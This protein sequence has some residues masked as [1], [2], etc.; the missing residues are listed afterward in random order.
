LARHAIALPLLAMLVL[1]TFAHAGCVLPDLQKGGSGYQISVDPASLSGQLSMQ[2]YV[3]KSDGTQPCAMAAE[4]AQASGY[5]ASVTP[6]EIS[7]NTTYGMYYPTITATA[8]TGAAPGTISIRFMDKDTGAE[9][10]TVP[11]GI[12]ISETASSPVPTHVCTKENTKDCTA[13]ELLAL[14]VGPSLIEENISDVYLLV[15]I[16]AGFALIVLIFFVV[17]PRR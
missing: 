5:A 2:I 1:A 7:F 11:I 12:S 8:Q 17:I 3:Q 4:L 15:G 14:D 6:S 9:I 10:A 13:K 16:I